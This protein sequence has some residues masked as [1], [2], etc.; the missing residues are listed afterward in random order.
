M[1]Q[2]TGRRPTPE[3]ALATAGA[4]GSA[5]AAVVALVLGAVIDSTDAGLAAAVGALLPGVLALASL[6]FLLAGAALGRG[7]VIGASLVAFSYR[8]VLAFALLV[9]VARFTD[10]PFEP[11][12]L[13]MPLGLIGSIG[14]EMRRTVR[15][16]RLLELDEASVAERAAQ[17]QEWVE[18][19]DA[20]ASTLLSETSGPSYLPV[21][22][23]RRRR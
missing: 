1:A 15:D 17:R 6:P 23:Q 12:A 13:G 19:R 7:A 22:P 2:R 5:A 20:A 11:L 14:A 18:A 9:A 10:L 3:V 16:P 8:M 4:I 21:S